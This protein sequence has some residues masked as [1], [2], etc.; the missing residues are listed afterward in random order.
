MERLLTVRESAKLLGL[1]ENIVRDYLT[2]GKIQGA[3]FG[4]VWR[5]HPNDLRIFYES[6][7]VSKS[8]TV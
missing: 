1:T 7:K 5:I 3:K 8:N 6:H 2:A 4:R